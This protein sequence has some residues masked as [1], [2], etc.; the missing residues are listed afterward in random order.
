MYDYIKTAI[1]RNGSSTLKK[2]APVLNRLH[3][4]IFFHRLCAMMR[5]KNSENE[6]ISF[7]IRR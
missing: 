2:C 3:E 7:L 5:E 4:T 6:K 1:E